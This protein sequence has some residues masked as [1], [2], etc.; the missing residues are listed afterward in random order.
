MNKTLKYSI[1]A[2]AFVIIA[3]V[4]IATQTIITDQSI[5]ASNFTCTD[6]M[7]MAQI[8]DIF[9]FNTG[10]TWAGAMNGGGYNLI[11]VNNLNTTHVHASNLYG[12]LNA[13]YLTNAPWMRTTIS[14]NLN[15][16]AYDLYGAT[17]GNFT[18]VYATGTG[19][20]ATVNTGQGANELY[21]MNQNVQ[22]TSNVKFAVVNST[23]SA[24]LT[25]L[26]LLNK[27]NAN[28]KDIYGV[29]NLNTTHVH[30]SNLY[31]SLNASYLTNAPW[32][33]TTISSNLNLNAYDLYGATWVNATKIKATTGLYGNLNASYITNPPWLRTKGG[34]M[35]G[36]IALGNNDVT[37]VKDM[38]A[39]S[40]HLTNLYATNLETNLD[41]TGFKV[42]AANF[43]CT[44]CIDTKQIKDSYLLNNG[45][46][47]T[48]N[49]SFDS[50]TL[51]VDSTHNAIGIGTT[52]P[53]HTAVLDMRDAYL[54]ITRGGTSNPNVQISIGSGV[55]DVTG[56]NYFMRDGTAATTAAPFFYILNNNAGDDQNVFNIY[57]MGAGD[58]IMLD[59]NGANAINI[60]DG[61]LA[62]GSQNITGIK[63]ATATTFKGNL[64]ASYV[65]N[66]P[67]LRTKGGT[68]S[69]DIAL[70]N[71]DVTG[72]KDMNAT[73]AHLTN[74]YATK[75]KVNMNMTEKNMTDTECIVFQSGGKIC[76]G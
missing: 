18:N 33:R 7:G 53:F 70:G 69:G 5:S 25:G 72:V 43:S 19:T 16:N 4:A 17:W 42:T 34:T 74:L 62:M 57:Q 40:A 44:D 46:T 28:S 12:S 37:G 54:S 41:G 29:N 47:A 30:A 61:N 60:V 51:F 8:K 55:D 6:C 13:S 39:T 71:N 32:M 21:G 10:D 67:W 14:S 52:D 58:G 59:A 35:S 48:G 49:Y 68:M 73:S 56:T 23:T 20:F 3:S 24:S 63:T 22:T 65:T 38:N 64:N 75:M 45:D 36:D 15:L 76:T 11:N 26:K 31:G 2:V 50:G 27:A 9:L 1:F 66:P